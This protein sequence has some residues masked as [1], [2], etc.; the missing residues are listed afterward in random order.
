[1]NQNVD[2]AVRL[3][4]FLSEFQKLSETSVLTTDQYARDGQVLTLARLLGFVQ[5]GTPELSLS[6]ELADL[7]D[8]EKNKDA[9]FTLIDGELVRFA[10]AKQVPFPE[11]N[12]ADS[13]WLK[14]F[15][16]ISSKKPSILKTIS[17]QGRTMRFEDLEPAQKERINNSLDAFFQWA[18]N[19]KYKGL[20]QQAFEIHTSFQNQSDEFE[21][22]LGFVNLSWQLPKPGVIDRNIFTTKLMSRMDKRTG[23][24]S[25]VLDD[26]HLQP[27]L[28]MIPPEEIQDQEFVSS[29]QEAADR[30]DG[31]LLSANSFAD[32]GSVAAVCLHMTATY[33]AS[34]QSEKAGASPRLTWK[35]TILLRK[36]RRLSLSGAFSS[37]SEEILESGSIPKGLVSLVDPNF[38][39]EVTA[40]TTNGATFTVDNEVFL[41]LPLNKKQEAVLQ[42]VDS[43]PHTIV[44]GPPGTGKTHMA[45]AL[46]SHLLAQ[47]KRVLVTAQT[48]RA[49]YE[50]RGK[51]PEEVRELAVSVVSGGKEDLAELRNAIDNIKRRSSSFDPADAQAKI[52]SKEAKLNQL[53]QERVSASRTLAEANEYEA[54]PLGLRRFEGLSLAKALEK[55]DLEKPQFEWILALDV[56]FDKAFPLA[57][58]EIEELFVLIDDPS[59]TSDKNLE[60]ADQVNLRKFPTPE[61]FAAVCIK[62]QTAVEDE[63]DATNHVEPS[64]LGR[65]LGL[66]G[67]Q[68]SKIKQIAICAAELQSSLEKSNAQ[69]AKEILHDVTASNLDKWIARLSSVQEKV[70][71]LDELAS[72]LDGVRRF[73]LPVEFDRHCFTADKLADYLLSGGALKTRADGSVKTGIFT[74]STV[75]DSM[76]FFDE[77]KINGVPPTTLEGIR[78]YQNIVEF[79][80]AAEDLWKQ[81]FGGSKVITELRFR[82]ELADLRNAVNNTQ[83]A[84]DAGQKL[85]DCN[86]ELEQLGFEDEIG[87]GDGLILLIGAL[88]ASVEAKHALDKAIRDIQE[89]RDSV[90]RAASRSDGPWI[91]KITEA[92]EQPTPDLYETTLR[93][94]EN[95]SSFSAPARRKEVLLSSLAGWSQ[96][97]ADGILSGDSG[98]WRKRVT[99]AQDALDWVHSGR[100]LHARKPHDVEAIQRQIHAIDNEITETITSLAAD[101]AWSASLGPDRIDGN[102][103]AHLGA[104]TGAVERLGKGTGKYA[105]KHRKDVRRH[106]DACRSAVPVWIMPIYKVV[107]QF[108]L[109][110]D[111]FDVVVIDEASQAGAS[112]IFLQ[113]LAPRIVVIG[114]DKQVSPL[115]VGSK[116]EPYEKLANQYLYDFDY[117]DAWADPKRSLFAD[118]DMRYGGRIVLDEHRRCVPEIIEYSNQLV[119]RPNNIELKPVRQVESDRLP[120]FRITHTPNAYV[121][122]DTNPVEASVLVNRLKSAIDDPKYDGKSFGVIVLK[123]SNEQAAHIQKLLLEQLPPTVWEDRDLKVGKPADFQGAERDVIFLSMTWAA[124]SDKRLD[125]VSGSMFEQR[126]NVAVSRAK[127]QVWLFHSVSRSDL[128]NPEDLRANLL[129]YAY[130]VANSRPENR[131]SSLVSNDERE[132]PF[133]S[134]FE[135]RVYNEL[136]SR[137]Y[138]VVPQKEEFGYRIDLVVEGSQARLAVECDGDHWH[139]DDAALKDQARQRQLERLGWKFCRLFESDFYLDREAAVQKIIDHLDWAGVEPYAENEMPAESGDSITEVIESIIEIEGIPFPEQEDLDRESPEFT[140]SAVT[141]THPEHAVESLPIESRVEEFSEPIEPYSFLDSVVDYDVADAV[142]ENASLQI[143]SSDDSALKPK[144]NGINLEPYTEFSGTTTTIQVASDSEIRAG[145]LFILEAEGPMIGTVLMARYNNA[146]GGRRLA[147][148][149]KSKLRKSLY[150]LVKDNAVICLNHDEAKAWQENTFRL[151]HQRDVHL[152]ELGPRDLYQIPF[153]E[154]QQV[155]DC[156]CR[157]YSGASEEMQMRMVLDVLGLSNLTDKA[158]SKLR[159][160]L[161]H[162]N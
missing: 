21:L 160:H 19:E 100:R 96:Q 101:R 85:A 39:A 56:D 137:G 133:D 130:S 110:Q 73:N 71:R 111:M 104:Y 94:I 149:M 46:L 138:H 38:E 162:I 125:Q 8:Q 5:N 70:T 41:P 88:E 135:Q 78:Y 147:N 15:V 117:K 89:V 153:E 31:S 106:L 37:I 77:V 116:L 6:A 134:L 139:G 91:K 72:N 48:E 75:K 108:Q 44:Q 109:K 27:E 20:Y 47:G 80:W 26:S 17:V 65:W 124:Q 129:D 45:A 79:F 126:F 128:A 34:L 49:L 132:E 115:A 146:G 122:A 42:R 43:H 152:R 63:R 29:I 54:K 123:S 61:K 114:D 161:R 87:T 74:S 60:S 127:D 58:T 120:P 2:K 59:L 18:R 33:E 121:K 69:W 36:R 50:L 159:V 32:L 53:R 90:Q 52:N 141:Q 51:M 95:A 25:F 67:S 102:M 93:E 82:A 143:A 81:G 62:L 112:A 140:D 12:E 4:R 55:W 107:E 40:S 14:D 151:P 103:R 11:L 148:A 1:M 97:L 105:D 57:S 144:F 131:Q 28:E 157:E 92:I 23:S 16:Q 98:T 64:V 113:Y 136:V 118:A 9:S 86:K 154:L 83:V 66:S 30:I 155:V 3:F 150:G 76:A 158:K 24:I 7:A 84:L 13:P 99:G 119:Y 145:L 22:V 10:R 142:A 35:P 68:R 156:V